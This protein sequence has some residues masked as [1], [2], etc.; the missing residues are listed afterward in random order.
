MLFVKQQ[1]TWLFRR[2]H[3]LYAPN[4]AAELNIND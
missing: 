3:N 1:N 4:T 2:L